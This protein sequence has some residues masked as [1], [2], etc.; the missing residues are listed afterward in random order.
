[1][2]SFCVADEVYAHLAS[3]LLHAG[4]ENGVQGSCRG[5]EGIQIA[6]C[7]CCMHTTLGTIWMAILWLYVA[8]C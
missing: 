8:V 5:V 1:M 4:M 2:F 6:L 7:T 3:L